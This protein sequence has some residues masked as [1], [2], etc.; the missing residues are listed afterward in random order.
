M[1]KQAPPDLRELIARCEERYPGNTEKQ[2]ELMLQIVRYC[3]TRKLL[4]PAA[5]ET[6]RK[7]AE[8]WPESIR[9]L[10]AEGGVR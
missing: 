7:D 9:E 8:K 2:L 1:M 10:L 4:T 5:L 6:L 3:I